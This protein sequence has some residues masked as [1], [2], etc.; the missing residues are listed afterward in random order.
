M[1]MKFVAPPDGLGER[2]INVEALRELVL[3][4]IGLA[5]LLKL[6]YEHEGHMDEHVSQVFLDLIH[7]VEQQLSNSLGYPETDDIPF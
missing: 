5:A 1:K 3:I 6:Q 7:E 2:V 4:C